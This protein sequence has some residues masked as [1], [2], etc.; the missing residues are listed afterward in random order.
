MLHACAL[1]GGGG[2]L[3]APTKHAGLPRGGRAMH[4]DIHKQHGCSRK[5]LIGEESDG[6]IGA[7]LPNTDSHIS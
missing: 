2:D 4:V 7:R 6:H 3:H 1:R 5:L